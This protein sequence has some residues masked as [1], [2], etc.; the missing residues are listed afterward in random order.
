MSGQIKENFH[1]YTLQ[2]LHALLSARD[3]FLHLSL[4]LNTCIAGIFFELASFKPIIDCWNN[5]QV[6]WIN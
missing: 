6:W 3:N 2:A 5:F 4:Q 1:Y